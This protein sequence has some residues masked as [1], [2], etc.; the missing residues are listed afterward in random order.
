M[1]TTWV[2]LIG[3][4][5]LLET[6]GD[7]AIRE[8]RETAEC[9]GRVGAVAEQH[10]SVVCVSRGRSDACMVSSQRSG[11]GPREWHPGR[12]SNT[13]TAGGVAT[14]SS[15]SPQPFMGGIRD[16]NRWA[17]SARA[18]TFLPCRGRKGGGANSVS[19][20]VAGCA[21]IGSVQPASPRHR[22][23]YS[24]Y[25]AYEQDSELKHEYCDGE[26][27][28]MASGS[29]RHNALALRVGA[30]LDVGCEHG[31]VA[32]QSDQKVRVL[33]TGR[34]TYPDATVVCGAIEGDP[35]DPGGATIT[36]P[37]VLVEVL[38]ASTEQE[39]RGGKWQHYQ[40]IPAL[41]EYVL[42]AQD[43]PRVERYRRIAGDRWEYTEVTKGALQLSTGAVLDLTALYEN[44]PD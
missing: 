6:V 18:R 13:V 5:R 26:I 44:L 31:C 37:T 33:A 30:A 10:L 36:N 42:V 14:R 7:V 41:K 28:A 27:L 24:E 35:A 12:A 19:T 15:E 43:G 39:D 29:R 25:L 40:L 34:A 2:L 11:A 22:Y 38:S 16:A 17:R 8:F 9:E 23:T 1:S 3:A 21:T 4:P 20:R 32:F